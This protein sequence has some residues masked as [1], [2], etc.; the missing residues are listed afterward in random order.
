M[1]ELYVDVAYLRRIASFS[2]GHPAPNAVMFRPKDKHDISSLAQSASSN[3]SPFCPYLASHPSTATHIACFSITI[4][5]SFQYDCAHNATHEPLNCLSS[6]DWAPSNQACP[7]SLFSSSNQYFRGM[8]H[9]LRQAKSSFGSSLLNALMAE[10]VI[11][12]EDC[13]GNVAFRRSAIDMCWLG[14]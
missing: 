4:L 9:V 7:N 11:I 6:I 2:F 10:W 5:M 14:M 3:S 13:N 1:I 8:G 12:A